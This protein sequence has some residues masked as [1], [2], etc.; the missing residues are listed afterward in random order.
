MKEPRKELNIKTIHYFGET[1]D[2]NVKEKKKLF[3]ELAKLIV[4]KGNSF[5]EYSRIRYEYKGFK[6][7]EDCFG[8]WVIVTNEK[9]LDYIRGFLAMAN[10]K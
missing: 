5:E 10:N 2:P 6:V 8:E 7:V 1:R 3:L 9:S 4:A